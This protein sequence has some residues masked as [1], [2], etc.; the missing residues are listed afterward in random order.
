MDRYAFALNDDLFQL[1]KNFGENLNT[2]FCKGDETGGLIHNFKLDQ[3]VA[4]DQF[5]GF[6]IMVVDKI[7]IFEDISQVAPELVGLGGVQP[8]VVEQECG[9]F[10]VLMNLFID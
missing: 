8:D 6:G 5:A 2:H 7:V 1:H 10:H 9:F 4:V 3:R